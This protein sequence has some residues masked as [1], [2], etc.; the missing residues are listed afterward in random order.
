MDLMNMRKGVKSSTE[1]YQ[2]AIKSRDELAGVLQV[3]VCETLQST[4]PSGDLVEAST[5][6]VNLLI[7]VA[8]LFFQSLRQNDLLLGIG[9]SRVPYERGET[10]LGAFSCPL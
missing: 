4:R 9:K 7:N 3:A 2:L 1:H 8:K 5:S 10:G 6:T